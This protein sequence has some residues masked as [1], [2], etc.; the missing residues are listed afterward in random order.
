MLEATY[1]CALSRRIEFVELVWRAVLGRGKLARSPALH[2]QVHNVG[3]RATRACR[4]RSAPALPRRPMPR[5]GVGNK[6]EPLLKD[7]LKYEL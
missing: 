3:G 4:S 6:I 1:W 5:P 7:L 2:R